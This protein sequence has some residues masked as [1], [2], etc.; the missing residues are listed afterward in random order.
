M[1][2]LARYTFVAAFLILAG[3]Q[4]KTPPPPTSAPTPELHVKAGDLMKDFGGNGI[5]AEAKYKGKV[6]AVTGKFGSVQKAPL[7]GFVVQLLPEDAGDVNL[8]AVQCPLVESA[9]EEVGKMQEGQTITLI[10]TCEGQT[11]GQI[12]MSKCWIGKNPPPEAGKK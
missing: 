11:V 7:L 9:K 12:K 3:C 5:A 2:R 6:I 4:N 8:S 1:S 10:G